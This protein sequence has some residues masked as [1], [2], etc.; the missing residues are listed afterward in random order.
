MPLT[1]VYIPDRAGVEFA[2]NVEAKS[3]GEAMRKACE[4]FNDPFWKG[5]KPRPGMIL[6]ILP[7]G[8]EAVRVRV[9]ES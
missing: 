1:T 6:R 8:G 5:P 2:T 7:M 4:F 9:P 3:S